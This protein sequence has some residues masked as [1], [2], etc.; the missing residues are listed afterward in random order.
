[1]S[2]SQQIVTKKV[3]HTHTVK[4][5]TDFNQAVN[6]FLVNYLPLSGGTLTGDL[7]ALNISATEIF[8]NEESLTDIQIINYDS[9]YTTVS[10]MSA[11]WG[12]GGTDTTTTVQTHSASWQNSIFLAPINAPGWYNIPVTVDQAGLIITDQN[13]PYYSYASFHLP[14]MEDALGQGVFKFLATKPQ[15]LNYFSVYSDNGDSNFGEFC[16]R[17]GLNMAQYSCYASDVG[18]YLELMVLPVNEMQAWVYN[19][20]GY[21]NLGDAVMGRDS[22]SIGYFTYNQ[23]NNL[24]LLNN[25]IGNFNNGEYIDVIDPNTL[26]ITEQGGT[27]IA[28][29]VS[30]PYRWVSLNYIGNWED[31]D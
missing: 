31:R 17:I 19:W 24:I 14:P 12:N 26:T 27:Q 15:S 2:C 8:I 11:T 18:N 16:F 3:A 25:V 21:I 6:G 1:M 4:D 22:G 20:Y 29:N 30:C 7:S 9:T 23:N 13:V 10:G 28:Y 5:I